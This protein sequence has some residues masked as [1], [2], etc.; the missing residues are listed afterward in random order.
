MLKSRSLNA[1]VVVVGAAISTI[2]LSAWTIAQPDAPAGSASAVAEPGELPG[3][4]HAMLSGLVGDWTS[5]TTLTMPTGDGA[6]GAE[7]VPADD[8]TSRA[9]VRIESTMEG[10]FIALHETGTMLGEA[11][12]AM[13]VFGFNNAAGVYEATWLYTGSTATMR[14]RGTPD[15]HNPRILAFQ[16]QYATGPEESQ[17]FL[18]TMTLRSDDEF[19]VTLTALLPDGSAGPALHTVYV[20]ER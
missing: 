18:V 9:T 3:S 4:Q 5:A 14:M 20:R 17:R 13:K 8:G 6:D 19:W 12:T 16:A 7:A 11:F 1:A 15:D 10:R 2:G